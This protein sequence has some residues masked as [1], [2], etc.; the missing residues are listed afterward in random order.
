MEGGLGVVRA[1]KLTGGKA[2]LTVYAQRCRSR[3]WGLEG[4]S[5]GEPAGHYLVRRDG[6]R[7]DLGCMSTVEIVEGDTVYIQRP[8]AEAM[9]TPAG[10]IGALS[11][12][13]LERGRCRRRRQP[14]A[15]ATVPTPCRRRALLPILNTMV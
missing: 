9:E 7:M 4:G 10:G 6:S 3:P 14:K 15:T 11:R 12:G 5:P 1:F 8:V 2:T 13:I